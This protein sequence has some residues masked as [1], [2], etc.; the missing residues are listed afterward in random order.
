[1]IT[2]RILEVGDRIII[3]TRKLDRNRGQY[4]SCSND[5]GGTMDVPP[6]RYSVLVEKVWHDYECGWR[7]TGQLIN[8]RDVEKLRKAGATS[9][10]PKKADW[11]PGHVMFAGEV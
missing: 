9:Y 7:A 2:R 5:L 6:G 11:Q 10:E 8:H 4:F 1:M 3:D